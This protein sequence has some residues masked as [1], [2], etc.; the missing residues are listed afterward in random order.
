MIVLQKCI[1]DVM[2][3]MGFVRER[4]AFTPHLTLARIRENASPQDIHEFNELVTKA[5]FDIRYK[6]EVNSINL[7]KSRLL[8]SGAVYSSLAEIKLRSQT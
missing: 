6:I 2:A 1:D 5:R 8:S 7:I 4:R 3:P